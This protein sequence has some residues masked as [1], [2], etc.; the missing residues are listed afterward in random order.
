MQ[1]TCGM[2]EITQIGQS[3]MII[4]LLHGIHNEFLEKFICGYELYYST[5]CLTRCLKFRYFILVPPNRSS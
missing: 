3:W 5:V 1:N 2:E 4:V